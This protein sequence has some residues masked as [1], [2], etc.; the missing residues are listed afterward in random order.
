MKKKCTQLISGGA[1]R[2]SRRKQI[3]FVRQIHVNSDT[4]HV[5]RIANI[6]VPIARHISTNLLF[7]FHWLHVLVCK[8]K[9]LKNI[10]YRQIDLVSVNKSGWIVENKTENQTLCLFKCVFLMMLFANKVF[11]FLKNKNNCSHTHTHTNIET[12]RRTLC[13]E[14]CW[15]CAFVWQCRVNC[16]AVTCWWRSQHRS[17]SVAQSPSSS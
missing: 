2:I 6:I 8:F 9:A 1:K 12:M 5:C 13:V 14:K 10:I 3:I 11:C 7:Q 15:E 16:S 17:Q 4:D